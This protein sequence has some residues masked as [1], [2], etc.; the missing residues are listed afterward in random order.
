MSCAQSQEYHRN[1]GAA[2]AH[3]LKYQSPFFVAGRKVLS[4]ALRSRFLEIRFSD[5]P[6]RELTTILEKRCLI[7]PSH[8]ARLV[9][10]MQALQR[11]RAKSRAFEGPWA[12][13]TPRDVFRWAL[14]GSGGYQELAEN[15]YLLL[16]G[17]LRVQEE[18]DIVQQVSDCLEFRCCVY[19]GTRL[20]ALFPAW[21]SCVR[22]L[23]KVRNTKAG[24]VATHVVAKARQSSALKGSKRIVSCVLQSRHSSNSKSLVQEFNA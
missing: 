22:F 11:R 2:R 20:P 21:T 10:A 19:S 24:L 16:A 9:D 6:P 13:I 7:A 4:R 8:A 3:I 12:F 15:G 18:R 14:R 5:L 23:G 1:I 17:S